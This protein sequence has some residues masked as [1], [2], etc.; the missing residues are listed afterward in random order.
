MKGKTKGW[1]KVLVE[2]DAFN[3]NMELV[4]LKDV[5]ALK[6]SKGIV[7]VYPEDVHKALKRVGATTVR[8][9]FEYENILDNVKVGDMV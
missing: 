6:N 4:H 9:P 2:M 3:D 1:Y 5:P 7:R 8:W